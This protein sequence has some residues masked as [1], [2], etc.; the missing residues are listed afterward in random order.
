[1]RQVAY[2]GKV[3]LNCLTLAN[4]HRIEVS[5]ARRRVLSKDPLYSDYQWADEDEARTF[6]MVHVPGRY[7]VVI[8]RQRYE[9]FEEAADDYGVTKNTI[10]RRVESD[11]FPNYYTL[12]IAPRLRG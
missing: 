1:M 8:G 3:Y 9:S 4:Q 6:T 5:E 2:R 7:K 12:V 11:Y 10:R